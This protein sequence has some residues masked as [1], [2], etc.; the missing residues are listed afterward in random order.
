MDRIIKKW[1]IL[2]CVCR[3][4]AVTILICEESS[5]EQNLLW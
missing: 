4:Q 2:N 3:R 1:N 5:S